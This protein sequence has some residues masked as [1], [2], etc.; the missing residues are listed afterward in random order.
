[1]K[2]N[3]PAIILA[4]VLLIIAL[5]VT[6]YPLASNYVSDKYRSEVRS[7]YFTAIE[8]L[9]DE[10]ITQARKAAENYNALLSAGISENANNN[11]TSYEDILNVN[12]DGIMAYIEIPAIDI[13][14]PVSHSTDAKTLENYV[15]HV[16]GSSV[17]VG[18]KGTHAV[19]SGH[20]GMA[21]QRMFSDLG[22][23]QNGYMVFIHVLNEV[24]VYE[25]DGMNT[26]LPGDTSLL[27]IEPDKDCLT[28]ITC[29]PIGV[30][31]H[32]LL[33][34]CSRTEYEP[35]K[36]QA[37]NNEAALVQ[38]TWEQEYI[39]GILFG[40]AVLASVVTVYV[41]VQMIRKQRRSGNE[42]ES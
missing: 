19:I 36:V 34:H 18:G 15:G 1:M 7:E 28:L 13:Y 24:L 25:V 21:G 11:H 4:I 5:A 33:V 6:A 3:R 26:V 41:V 29:M 38:S 42:E 32:R 31:T 8:Q 27:G 14:L 30:N 16:T 22:D 12:G 20:S 9:D 35:E 37:T 40:L 17:P 10:R 23:L 39:R 2:N